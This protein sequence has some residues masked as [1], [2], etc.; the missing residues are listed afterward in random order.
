MEEL[1]TGRIHAAECIG[2]RGFGFVS[3]ASLPEPG[4]A[5]RHECHQHLDKVLDECGGDQ[6]KLSW[7]LVELQRHFP[8][9]SKPLSDEQQLALA[10]AGEKVKNPKP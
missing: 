4:A 2:P 9:S 5:V 3:S 7:T 8:V 6:H 1:L 10:A